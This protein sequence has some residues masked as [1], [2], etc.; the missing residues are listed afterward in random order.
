[1]LPSA[2]PRNAKSSN[3]EEAMDIVITYRMVRIEIEVPEKVL[4]ELVR[5]TQV[6][7]TTVLLTVV[8]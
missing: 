7:V 4:M 3:K 8:H 5:L 6:I 2:I 1:M